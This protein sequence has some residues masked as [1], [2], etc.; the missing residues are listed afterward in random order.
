MYSPTT[1]AGAS[2]SMTSRHVPRPVLIALPL[3]FAMSVLRTVVAAVDPSDIDVV[4][5]VY[6]ADNSIE[7]AVTCLLIA[8]LFEL[9]QRLTGHT[10]H[11]ALIAFG[12]TVLH[13]AISLAWVP[14]FVWLDDAPHA[15]VRLVLQ[16]IW[17]ATDVLPLLGLAL[18]AAGRSRVVAVLALVVGLAA[19]LPPALLERLIEALELGRSGRSG[20]WY[21]TRGVHAASLL[22]LV[23]AAAPLGAP[24]EAHHAERG[25]RH[26]ARALRLRVFAFAVVPGLTLFAALGMMRGTAGAVKVAYVSGLVLQVASQIL[27]GFG[28]LGVAR[29]R[30]A[31]LPAV[32]IYAAA[33]GSLLLAGYT[34]TQAPQLYQV[35]FR[36]GNPYLGERIDMWSITAPLVGI[37]ALWALTSAI[38]SFA[39]TR[40]LHDLRYDASGKGPIG[41]ALLFVAFADLQ[42]ILPKVAQ[43]HDL[44]ILVLLLTVALVIVGTLMLAKLC[45]HAADT[46]G[47]QTLPTARLT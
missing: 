10:R 28:A 22:L 11:G 31:D 35:M 44:V 17:Y 2:L 20:L 46:V 14:L 39:R 29:A 42:W 21:A 15:T 13:L 26:A 36:D 32:R 18:A 34:A 40:N 19:T 33:I 6:I 3:L 45:A 23:W 7:Y 1:E 16:Y 47:G 43:R 24:V 5:R 8:G 4:L 12:A 30:L 9:A 27:L 41:C 38:T 25:L 37:A